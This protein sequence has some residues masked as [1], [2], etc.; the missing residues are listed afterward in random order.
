MRLLR[1]ARG[2]TLVELVVVA[3]VLGILVAAVMPRYNATAS[4]LAAEQDAT[5]IS[6]LLRYGRERAVSQGRTVAFVWDAGDRQGRLGFEDVGGAWTAW[7][8]RL[9]Y[10]RVIRDTFAVQ[11]VDGEAAPLERVRFYPDGTADAAHVTL[12]L[13]TRVYAIDVDSATGQV[14]LN[15]GSSAR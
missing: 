15:A 9:A 13:G 1:L 11:L 2:F 8:E 5:D 3:V 4:R 14:R 12:T 7:T 6:R 10:T